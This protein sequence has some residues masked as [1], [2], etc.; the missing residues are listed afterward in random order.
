MQSVVAR[1]HDA[2]MSGSGRTMT[3][4]SPLTMYA[5]PPTGELTL[6][7]FE[8]VALNR[9]RGKHLPLCPMWTTRVCL[10]REAGGR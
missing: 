4:S 7:D 2:G 1:V 6:Y 3:S 9:L 8:V 5:E 10:W